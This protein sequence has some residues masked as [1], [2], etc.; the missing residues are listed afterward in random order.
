MRAG[1]IP[2][3]GAGLRYLANLKLTLAVRD[4]S[5]KTKAF[6]KN[7]GFA[8]KYGPFEMKQA[9]LGSHR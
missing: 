6:E 3:V 8:A 9:P 1:I 7:T 4:L 2:Q 5:K